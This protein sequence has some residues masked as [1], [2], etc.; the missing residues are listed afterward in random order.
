MSAISVRYIEVFQWEFN[1]DSTGSLKSIRYYQV[2]NVV[3]CM[4][5][6]FHKLEPWPVVL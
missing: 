3:M 2:C 6:T 1:H 5:F 4:T